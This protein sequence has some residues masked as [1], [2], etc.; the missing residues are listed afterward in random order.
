VEQ[1]MQPTSVSLWLR[2]PAERP[3]SHSIRWDY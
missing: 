3:K 1:A 2:P